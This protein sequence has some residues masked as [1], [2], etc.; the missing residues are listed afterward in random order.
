MECQSDLDAP[1]LSGFT[2]IS[3]VDLENFLNLD[4]PDIDFHAYLNLDLAEEDPDMSDCDGKPAFPGPSSAPSGVLHED[5]NVTD[6]LLASHAWTEENIV[7]PHY[8]VK[9]QLTAPQAYMSDYQPMHPCTQGHALTHQQIPGVIY[10]SQGC[11]IPPSASRWVPCS[12]PPQLPNTQVASQFTPVNAG[13]YLPGY[14][15]KQ[16]LPFAEGLLGSHLPSLVPQTGNASLIQSILG[17]DLDPAD[18]L[19]GQVNKLPM[20]S[21]PEAVKEYPVPKPVAIDHQPK[22]P[23]RKPL[24]LTKPNPR[25]APHPKYAPLPHPP[26]PWSIY[27]YTADGEL[28]PSRL[29]TPT[30]ITTYL[31]THPRPHTLTLRIHRNA[32]DSRHRYPTTHSHRCRF[33]TCPMYPNNTINQGH[34]AVSVSEDDG[35]LQRDPFLV[36]AWVHL[37]CLEK[38]TDFIRVCRDLNIEA[39]MRDLRLE[40]RGRNPFRLSTPAEERCVRGFIR[41]C[42]SGNVPHDYPL[43]FD[44]MQER[45]HEGT[46]THRLACVKLKREPSGVGKQRSLREQQAGYKGCTLDVHVGDLE[47]ERRVRGWTRRHGNQNQLVVRPRVPRRY[48]GVGFVGKGEEEEEDEDA[49]GEVEDDEEKGG[50][51]A[52]V[53]AAREPVFECQPQKRSRGE[54]RRSDGALDDRT[55]AEKV[56]S[57]DDDDSTEDEDEDEDENDADAL[58]QQKQELEFKL[59]ELKKKQKI[60]AGKR[61]KTEAESE[62]DDDDL[63]VPSRKRVRK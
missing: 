35:K 10:D 38:F 16:P 11:V 29:Y 14:P 50:E 30:E 61:A 24:L 32:P 55:A 19:Q 58:E 3:D 56:E 1:V 7:E 28:K 17:S 12:P 40:A 21:S 36:A 5:M 2:D 33:T 57:S 42:R 25:Y 48:R 52:W 46:L 37:Y 45:A 47:V 4:L 54:K 26:A 41:T 43:R 23:L 60:K 6:P 18:I 9:E 53:A 31:F 44:N 59:T 63:V 62:D 8:P 49:E 34:I 22:P 13:G 15:G 51:P 20:A 39:D 27:T